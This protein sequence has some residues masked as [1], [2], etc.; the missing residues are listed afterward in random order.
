MGTMQLVSSSLNRYVQTP[1][2]SIP[3][4]WYLEAADFSPPQLILRRQMN[5]H[6]VLLLDSTPLRFRPSL[7]AA[8]YSTELPYIAVYRAVSPP[9]FA[10]PHLEI[11]QISTL[12]C[13]YPWYLR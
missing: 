12:S 7:R 10:P 2:F 6:L 9:D 11:T 1:P 3:R 13:P 8:R 4:I 5:P